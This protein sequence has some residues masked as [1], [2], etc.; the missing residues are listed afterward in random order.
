[1]FKLKKVIQEKKLMYEDKEPE[2]EEMPTCVCC[3][4]Q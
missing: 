4:M 3:A 1:M 2:D